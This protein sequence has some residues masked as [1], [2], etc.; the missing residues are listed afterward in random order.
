MYELIKLTE[1]NYYIESP[2]KVG[3]IKAAD[4]K[5]V[6]IDS[7]NSKEAAKRIK[8]TLDAEGLE[9]AAIFNTHSHADHIGGNRYL[10]ELYGCRIHACG[11][12]AA[13]TA[14]PILEPMLLFGANPPEELRHKFLLAEQSRVEALEPRHLPA[15]VEIIHLG[16]HTMDMVGF[17]TEE[18]VIYLGD[19]LSSEQTLE[20]Y[21]ITYIYDVG[22][23][24]KTLERLKGLEAKCFVPAHA[25][26]T[27]DILPLIKTNI[28]SITEIGD[29]ITELLTEARSFDELLAEIFTAYGL[30]MTFEQHALVGSALRSY[31]TWLKE[32]GRI[33]ASIDSNRL[34]WKKL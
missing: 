1:N 9:V 15:G 4:G 27:A 32:S 21:K 13:M 19:C 30:L 14:Y 11:I 26:A 22:E 20:K 18:G 24:L 29:R 25:A 33:S 12:E 3:V 5:A 16:G 31:L 17:K 6:L 10:Q 34:V 8:R 23:H 28:D 7:G 2:A